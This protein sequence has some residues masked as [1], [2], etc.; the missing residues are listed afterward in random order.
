M[1]KWALLV[2]VAVILSAC[3]IQQGK[4]K[5]NLTL[6][7]ART[8]FTT[9][10][11]TRNQDRDNPPSPPKNLFELVKYPA[12]HGPTY[13]YLSKHPADGKKRPAIIWISGGDCN[14]IGESAWEEA[15][16]END[17]SARSFRQGGVVLMLPS[18][19]GGSGS[20]G[21]K[22]GFFGEVKDVLSA[23]D[24]LAAHPSVDPQRIYLGGHSTGATMAMLVAAYDPRFRA[25]FA[26]GPADD[27]RG[28]GDNFR[29]Y[30]PTKKEIE[31]RSP[32]RWLSSVGC[33]LF[34][35]EGARDPGNIESLRAME[36]ASANPLITFFAVPR[37]DH[38]TVLTPGTRLVTKKILKDTATGPTTIDFTKEEV[39]LWGR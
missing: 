16:L 18:L 1:S 22:E 31:L 19:R 34:V 17:Q 3:G 29:P 38:F 36:A 27:V 8:G 33:R 39:D 12:E 15:P 37:T 24:Y 10:L 21:F 7:E 11:L 14:S 13:A 2:G 30:R 32:V 35:F 25:V 20:P 6:K 9:T 4:P 26:F 28:Y 5:K 23:A